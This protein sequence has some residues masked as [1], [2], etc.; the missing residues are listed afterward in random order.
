[1][2]V[3]NSRTQNPLLDAATTLYN[4]DK[5]LRETF[6]RIEEEKNIVQSL[7]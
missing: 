4:I 5:S 3:R 1:M 7:Q 2:V 6:Q